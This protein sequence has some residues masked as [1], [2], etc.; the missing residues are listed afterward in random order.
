M[1]TIAE[2]RD[3][4]AIAGI[5]VEYSLL[6]RTVEGELFG[7]ARAPGLG[8]TPWS[9]LAGGVLSGKYTRDNRRPDGIF[10]LLDELAA[11]AVRL[12]VPTASLALAW[13]RQQPLVTTTLIGARTVEQLDA[14]VASLDVEIPTDDLTRLNELTPPTSAS[15]S[16]SSRRPH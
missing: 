5:Q 7:A 16:P 13:V 8:V 14:N 11:I 3:W 12:G 15:R 4:S 10:A 6:E 1:A 9:P 2:L